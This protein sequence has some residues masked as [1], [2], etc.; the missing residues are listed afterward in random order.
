[1]AKWKI[2]SR[3]SWRNK[4]GINTSVI[5]VIDSAGGKGLDSARI[6][7]CFMHDDLPPLAGRRSQNF[8][9]ILG[10]LGKKWNLRSDFTR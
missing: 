1:M 3:L 6:E 8:S 10:G 2:G 7:W 5:G 4:Q 9:Y